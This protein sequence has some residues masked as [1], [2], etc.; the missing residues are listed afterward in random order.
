MRGISAP[1]ENKEIKAPNK[2]TLRPNCLTHVWWVLKRIQLFTTNVCQHSSLNHLITTTTSITTHL[3]VELELV[4]PL[5]P[6]CSQCSSGPKMEA[7]PFDC[8]GK[9][10]SILSASHLRLGLAYPQREFVNRSTSHRACTYNNF[11]SLSIQFFLLFLAPGYLF[12][13]DLHQ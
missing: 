4:S 8:G 13:A 6:Q 5:Q 3:L 9:K 11:R 7:K 2:G 12:Q 1:L 10:S